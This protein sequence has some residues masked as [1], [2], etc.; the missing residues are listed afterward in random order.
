MTGTLA[1]QTEMKLL[2]LQTERPE[3]D[4]SIENVVKNNTLRNY[5]LDLAAELCRWEPDEYGHYWY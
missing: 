2:E 4:F 5:V 1:G 3:L